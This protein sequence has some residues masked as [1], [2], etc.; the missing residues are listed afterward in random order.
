MIFNISME[1]NH[2]WNDF[3][4]CKFIYIDK[5]TLDSFLGTNLLCELL[6]M[7]VDVM[8]HQ[9]KQVLLLDEKRS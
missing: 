1:K 3:Q 5:S 6:C 9:E 7:Y 2:G 4:I 8:M